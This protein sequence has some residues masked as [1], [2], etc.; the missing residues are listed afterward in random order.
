MVEDSS[1]W[2]NIK[3]GDKIAL[4]EL[5]KRYYHQMY[6]YAI[7]WSDGNQEVAEEIVSDCFIKLWEIR[8]KIEIQSSVKHYLFY[9]L[10][11]GMIDNFRKK[12]LLTE[13]LVEDLPTLGDEKDF[14][15]QKQYL[16]L[17]QELK[18]LPDQC[19]KV[20]ELAI[21]ESLTYNEIAEKLQITK[22]TVKTQMGRA[23][24]YLKERLNPKDFL[25]FFFL[26]KNK[27]A[28]D[29]I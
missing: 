28:S 24:K 5:H 21:F 23:Y 15:D 7:K 2:I 1:L 27:G 19:R 4:K 14:D 20:L 16:R 26:Y 8:K 13:P 10:Q 9:M 11:N 25:F 22:N 18:N 12:K 3:K 17:Y 6:L 29:F